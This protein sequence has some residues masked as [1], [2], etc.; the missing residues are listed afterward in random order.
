MRDYRNAKAMAQTLR[1]DL[2]EKSLTLSHSESLEL[3][4]HVLGFR[5]WNVLAAKI[6]SERSEPAAPPPDAKSE[7]AGRIFFCS[8]CGKSQHEV[9]KPIAGP[10]VFICDACVELCDDVLLDNDPAKAATAEELRLRTTEDLIVLKAKTARGLSASRELL[11]RL[12]LFSATSSDDEAGHSPSVRYFLKKP[13][14]Q[15][16]SHLHDIE[17]RIAS[18]ENTLAMS[19]EILRGRDIQI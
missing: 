13:L 19:Q 10:D 4:S 7:T 8:F 18:M 12:R 5:D 1:K 14:D 6:E 17:Q 11:D 15:R 9:A 16:Q 3:I 2:A